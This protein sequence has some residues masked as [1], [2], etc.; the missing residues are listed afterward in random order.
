VMPARM[1]P[2]TN[3]NFPPQFKF[4]ASAAGC[5]QWEHP[6]PKTNFHSTILGRADRSAR[7]AVLL[8]ADCGGAALFQSTFVES[9]GKP[10]VSFGV[11]EI[12]RLQAKRSV[13]CLRVQMPIVGAC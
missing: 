7:F 5:S 12:A 9:F 10:P 4:A 2:S 13:D 11:I 6:T 3:L 8:P 1:F